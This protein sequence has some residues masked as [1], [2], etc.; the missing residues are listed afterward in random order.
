MLQAIIELYKEIGFNSPDVLKDYDNDNLT[1]HK[2]RNGREVL[3]YVDESHN[4]A[5]YIDSLEFL[6]ED[7][8][9]KE[10]C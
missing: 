7:E 8:I 2:A 3:W 10:L 5:I 1:I 9:E 4:A 6:S